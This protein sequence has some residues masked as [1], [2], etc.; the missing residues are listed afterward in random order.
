MW[1]LA[2]HRIWIFWQLYNDF[3]CKLSNLP[4]FHQI[5]IIYNLLFNYVTKIT[6]F[7]TRVT[8]LSMNL[9][10]YFTYLQWQVVILRKCTF[11]FAYKKFN[12]WKKNYILS[13]VLQS[14]SFLWYFDVFIKFTSV[15]SLADRKKIGKLYTCIFLFLFMNLPGWWCKNIK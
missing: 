2:I 3:S 6:F 12:M 10:R 14:L 1:V 7:P 4:P 13:R 15:C 8:W 11:Y 9:D 5:S